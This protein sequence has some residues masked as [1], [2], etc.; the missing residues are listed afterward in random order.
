MWHATVGGHQSK[1]RLH[2]K[3]ETHTASPPPLY[4]AADKTTEHSS[5]QSYCPS[6][7]LLLCLCSL[8]AAQ[9]LTPAWRTSRPTSGLTPGRSRTCVSMKAATRPSPTPR[10]GPS[11]RTA[12]TLMRYVHNTHTRRSADTPS[13]VLGIWAVRDCDLFD[14]SC[15]ISLSLHFRRQYQPFYSPTCIY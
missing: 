8:R 11:T 1:S 15:F 12:H 3:T 5:S 14:Y 10:T 2:L 4:P 13:G 9:K 6:V 7:C